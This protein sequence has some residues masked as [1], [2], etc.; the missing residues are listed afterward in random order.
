M[1]KFKLCKRIIQ[2]AVLLGLM[3]CA[4]VMAGDTDEARA[5]L[6]WQKI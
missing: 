4:P 5:I 1:K 6:K 2:K 3:L